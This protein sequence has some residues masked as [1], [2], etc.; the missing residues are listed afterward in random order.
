MAV[1]SARPTRKV[2][3]LSITVHIRAGHVLPRR[4]SELALLDLP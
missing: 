3:I 2:D 1:G 4:P